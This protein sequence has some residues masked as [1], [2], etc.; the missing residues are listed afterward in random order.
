M[1]TVYGVFH[2]KDV[3]INTK[4][5]DKSKKQQILKPGLQPSAHGNFKDIAWQ[6]FLLIQK[7]KTLLQGFSV[8]ETNKF[9]SNPEMRGNNQVY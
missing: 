6:R 9:L 8:Y 4:Q 1:N 3:K 5:I 2:Q 7:I